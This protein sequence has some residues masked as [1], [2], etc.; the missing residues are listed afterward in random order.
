MLAVLCLSGRA[1]LMSSDGQLALRQGETCVV[2]A[3][4][5]GARV[6]LSDGHVMAAC[7]QS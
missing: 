5:E 2:P 6:V 7:V 3:E 4:T 1:D